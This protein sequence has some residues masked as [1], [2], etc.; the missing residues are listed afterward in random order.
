MTA[1][2]IPDTLPGIFNALS[3]Q[4]EAFGGVTWKDIGDQGADIRFNQRALH[5]T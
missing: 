4:T 2:A 1:Q 5:D 3:Q